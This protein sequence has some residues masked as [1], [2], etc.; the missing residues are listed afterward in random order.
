[1]LCSHSHIAL[2]VDLLLD[3]IAAA[4]AAAG[5]RQW[6]WLMAWFADNIEGA[7]QAWFGSLTVVYDG[8][9]AAAA[10]AATAAGADA[11]GA[12]ASGTATADEQ[13]QQG[14]CGT[15]AE[16]ESASDCSGGFGSSS[17]DSLQDQVQ[18]EQQQDAE[19]QQQQ[20][21]QDGD[22]QTQQQ[23]QQ[24]RYIF[25]FQP[26]G[27]YPTGAGFLPWMPSFKQHFPGVNPV[28]LTA[29]VIFFPPFIRD[30]CCW[31][32]FRQVRS[33]C[34]TC[35]LRAVKP[36]CYLQHALAWRRVLA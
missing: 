24:Q 19:E 27:L 30:I 4:A 29:T 18:Q 23:Q 21:K 10:L 17:S 22:Q 3:V 36:A 6:P 15:F 8:D 12:K 16:D 14:V 7:L 28:T 35:C 20:D 2:F 25:G 31:A 5:C 32:G 13:Q 9:A 11:T 34:S 33:Y 26:H 1:M